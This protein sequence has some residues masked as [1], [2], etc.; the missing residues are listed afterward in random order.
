M[1]Q[2]LIYLSKKIPV[3]VT[4]ISVF[5]IINGQGIAI[6]VNEASAEN[7]IGFQNTAK[8]P[9]GDL[10]TC[11]GNFI[12]P[13]TICVGS[14]TNDTIVGTVAGSIIFGKG[15]NDMI[16]GLLSQQVI[17]GNSGN[18]SI[19]G[20]NSTNIVFGNNGDDT[21]VGGSGFDFMKGGGG[22]LLAGN[23]GNDKLIG[24]P[25]HDVLE[26][27]PGFDFFQCNGKVD[28]ILDFNSHEDRASGNCI[29]S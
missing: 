1:S 23:V 25:D 22:S 6:A 8:T 19:Q 28:L 21:L 27:G 29:F 24:G 13:S 15:G 2:L 20:G 3:L 12:V 9:I 26:G 10:T 16:R 17:F 11:S 5:L 18:D 4:L 14:D 7:V